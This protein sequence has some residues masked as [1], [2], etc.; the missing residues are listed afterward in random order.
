MPLSISLATP[1]DNFQTTLSQPHTANSGTLVLTSVAGLGTPTTAN[2]IRITVIRASD[3]QRC[4]FKVTGISGNTLTVSVADGYSDL[5]FASGD[6]AG[7]FISAATI[8]DIHAALLST[9]PAN[10]V[11]L[12]NIGGVPDCNLLT[13]A[14]I[15]G[16]TPTDN[17]NAIN[18][19]LGTASQTN[20]VHLVIDG[21][22]AIGSAIL[23]PQTGYVTISG[24]GMSSGVF[25]KSGSNCNAIQNFPKTDMDNFIAWN[26]TGSQS[27]VGYNV[28]I[29]DL[30]IHGNRGTYP[31]GNSNGG[32]DGSITS[33]AVFDT[34]P[35]ARGPYTAGYWLSGIILVGIENLYIDNVWVYNAPTYQVNLFHC[36]KVWIN[37]SRFEVA[38]PSLPSNQ[39][40]VHCN[41][42]CSDVVIT[43]CWFSVG[44][45]PFAFNLEE[46]DGASGLGGTDLVADNCTLYNC[47]TAGRI[48][49]STSKTDRVTLRNIHGTVIYRGVVI[50]D[51]GK[52]PTGAD[53]NQHIRLEGMNLQ[54]TNNSYFDIS[55]FSICGNA[56]L[57]EIVDCT[58]V[59]PLY[60]I[61][62][63]R[64]T[65]QP[66]N[67]SSLKISNCQIHRNANGSAAANLFSGNTGSIGEMVVDRFSYSQQISQAYADVS[68]LI[69]TGG[70][71]I[72]KLVIDGRLQGVATVVN[73]GSGGYGGAAASIGHISIKDL[74]HIS[75]TGTNTAVAFIN[76]GGSIPL[77]ISSYRS[78]NVG[79]I[80]S[81]SFAISGPGLVSSGFSFAD[82]TIS[83]NS[84]YKSSTQGAL[85]FKDGGGSVNV[86]SF[87]TGVTTGFRFTGPT[88]GVVNTASTSFTITPIGGPY[89]GTVTITPSGGGLSTPTV[90]T[91]SSSTTPQTFTITP[92]ST[93]NVTL[94]VTNNGSLTN[95]SPLTYTVTSTALHAH[96]AG[97]FAGTAN[98][99]KG[100]P[101]SHVSTT[102][103]QG[104]SSP[105]SIGCYYRPDDNNLLTTRLAPL[106]AK[107]VSAKEYILYVQN[108]PLSVAY[109]IRNGATEYD[110]SAA[111]T[112]AVNT[113]YWFV[114]TFDG[115]K[116]HLY[117]NG[118]ED[119]TGLTVTCA[120]TSDD[121]YIGGD[122]TNSGF[123]TSGKITQVF[124]YPFALT[125]TQVAYMYNSG[126]GRGSTEILAQSGLTNPN[127]LLCFENS[128]DLGLDSSSNNYDFTP[129]Y[130]VG[131]TQ[132]AGPG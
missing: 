33:G 34:T 82:T 75:N 10:R 54:F 53:T 68:T 113:D 5:N 57:I 79:A 42:G 18:T 96:Y 87:L 100:T 12:S 58:M 62:M 44:D 86:F 121:L 15:G 103:L 32:R 126:A 94:T 107:W 64:M 26:P 40:G 99:N 43:N 27:I 116:A 109:A 124:K 76:T 17:A 98:T 90:L 115:T 81:G 120:V 110:Y 78:S 21:P 88:T 8:A 131:P 95:P 123:Q 73:A 30:K 118:V 28:V 130:S 45:D 23:I 132:T 19:F 7:V 36:H 129:V 51:E 14:K 37:A 101:I 122:G 102:A 93:G 83:N 47:F 55:M 29:R 106:I 72:G 50:G 74:V 114:L 128:N 24:T 11:N 56:G 105:W 2:P 127:L 4:H 31:N 104:G 92:T 91:F 3:S 65:N 125:P 89:S 108:S 48:Y 38:D 112:I 85:A 25:I 111:T 66:C 1:I 119:G 52:T 6:T 16:G 70:M 41:G 60:P 117:I 63:I 71:S 80:T 39:D 46:G 13:G 22:Y 20:P 49:G 59:A 84:I 77:Y 61:S 69:S 9:V 35:D 67:V 97:L